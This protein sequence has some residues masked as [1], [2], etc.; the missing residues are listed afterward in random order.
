[1]PMKQKILIVDDKRENLVALRRILKDVDAEVVEATS[2]NQALAATLNNHFAVAILD[3]MMPGMDGYELAEHLRDDDNTKVIPIVFVTASYYDELHMFKGYE[4]GGI[5]YIVKPFDPNVLLSKVKIFLE[6]DRYREELRE[7]RDN[8]KVLVYKRTTELNKRVKELRCMYEILSIAAVSDKTVDEIFKTVVK[9]IP[10]GWQYPE[11][12]CARI[13]SEGREFTTGNFRDTHWKQSKDIVVSEKIVGAVE[14]CFLEERPERDEGPFLK[15]ERNLIN[16]ISGQLG[17][18]VD[19][20]SRKKREKHLNAVLD[21][22]R[23]VNRLIVRENR[24]DRLISKTCN[25]IVNLRGFQAA[26]IILTASTS[27]KAIE[28]ACSGFESS[29]L[30]RLSVMLMKGKLPACCRRTGQADWGIIVTD[31]SG[32]SCKDCPLVYKNAGNATMTIGLGHNE[33]LF[34]WMG[35]SVPVEFTTDQDEISLL[36]EIAGDIAF[37]LYNM[38][39]ELKRSRYSQIVASSSEAMA[40]VGRKYEYLEANRSYSRMLTGEDT[41]LAGRKLEDVLGKAFFQNIVK[42]GL[43]RCFAGNEVRYDR[44][45]EVGGSVRFVDVIYTPCFDEE[46]NIFAVSVYVHDM[47]KHKREEEL[48]ENLQEQLRQS[49]KLEAVGRLSAGIAHDFNNLLTTIIGNTELALI[50]TGKDDPLYEMMEEVKEAGQKA[51][52][53]TGQLLAFSRKQILQPEMINLNEIINEIG[54]MLSRIIGE[55]IELRK[56]LAPDLEMINAD[57]GQIEQVIMNL[58]VNSRDAMPNGG[59]LTIETKNV[60]LDE[61][62]AD[63]HMQ[64]I[65]GSYVMLTISDSGM[66]IPREVQPHI[67]EPFFTT[68]DKGKGTGLGLSTVYGIIKQSNGYIWVYSEPGKGTTFKIYLPVCEKASITAKEVE[69]KEEVF[70]GFETVLLVEDNEMVRNTAFKALKHYGYHILCAADGQDAMRILREHEGIIHL[71][72]T[73]IVMP[74]MSGRELAEQVQGLL[75]DMKVLYMSGYTD[76]TIVNHGV[77]EKGIAFLQ[78]PFTPEGLARKVREVLDRV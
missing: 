67:F 28:A 9:L 68:K 49:Q 44:E 72:L 15:E 58:C 64:V 33:R 57:A 45:I 16:E 37:A 74:W 27:T 13:I 4:A 69:V 66:G 78:K 2:G 59:S 11:I 12:T 25:Y 62:Y 3:V 14:V 76:N 71:M 48:R 18:I 61:E 40:L 50:D 26:W 63:T 60:E 30:N 70:Q 8:L 41:N 20:E 32:P 1:M 54:N 36:T 34:G 42:P 56:E 24:R 47:T 39:I 17:I 75:P 19:R 5:D 21:S 43:D 53:L 38:D 35:V 31:V 73:D 23:S 22:I 52:C 51:S 77:L 46:G 7:H 6:L 55:D 29:V 10:H 65:P